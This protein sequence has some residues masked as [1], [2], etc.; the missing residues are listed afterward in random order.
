MERGRLG[1]GVATGGLRVACY[2][3][4]GVWCCISERDQNVLTRW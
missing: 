4:R 3:L 2:V 1:R